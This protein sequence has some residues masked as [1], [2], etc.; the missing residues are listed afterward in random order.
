[1]HPRVVNMKTERSRPWDVAI[2]RNTPWGNPFQVETETTPRG[3]STRKLSRSESLAKHE[4]WVRASPDLMNMIKGQL[5]GKVLGCY[6]APLPCH[7][8]T[9]AKIADEP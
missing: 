4:A 7:G 2:G 6:C 1:M 8:D 5:K 9:L 3:T